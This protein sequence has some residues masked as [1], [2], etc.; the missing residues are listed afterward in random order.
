[1]LASLT[2]TSAVRDVQVDAQQ[3]SIVLGYF[4]GQITISGH[5]VTTPLG[6]TA[7]DLYLAK[8]A[9]DGSFLWARAIGTGSA[10]LSRAKIAVDSTG[11]I[12]IAN[13]FNT[14]TTFAGQTL[15]YKKIAT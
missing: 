9:R 3:N 4:T 15:P 1:M 5:T 11:A 8:F 12:Y 13:M 7:Q 14:T 2:A 6:A 10:S